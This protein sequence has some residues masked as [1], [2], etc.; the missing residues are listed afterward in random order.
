VF[1]EVLLLPH[2]PPRY[3]SQSVP[4]PPGPINQEGY[5]E[6]EI[7]EILASRKRGRGIQ[8]LMKWEGY[9]NEENTWEPGAIWTMQRKSSLNSIIV[10]RMLSGD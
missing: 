3:P 1:N 8:Y 4:E 6:Y 9:G 10:I 5:P 7:E 2:H